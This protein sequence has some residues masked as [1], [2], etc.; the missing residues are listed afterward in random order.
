MNEFFKNQNG[1]TDLI[2]TLKIFY[3]YFKIYKQAKQAVVSKWK[4]SDVENAIKWSQ[5]IEELHPKFINK[6][7]Y[8][9]LLCNLKQL[10]KYWS[11]N[12]ANEV[13]ELVKNPSFVM[14]NVR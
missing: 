11:I 3:E 6:Q 10:S 8:E 2:N 9:K 12:E 4:V 14:K 7:Y 1:T 13:E 5:M